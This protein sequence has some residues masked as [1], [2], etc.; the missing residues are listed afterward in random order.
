MLRMYAYFKIIKKI[1]VL[2]IEKSKKLRVLRVERVP[3]EKSGFLKCNIILYFYTR[4]KG[5]VFAK[6][7]FTL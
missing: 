4:E 7:T 3:Y 5:R 6:N 1:L 2:L